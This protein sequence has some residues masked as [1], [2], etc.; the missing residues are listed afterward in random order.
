MALELKAEDRK[1]LGKKVNSLRR[2]GFI[3][4]VLYG[5]G[6]KSVAL[7]VNAK[8]FDNVFRQAGE[9]SLVHLASGG[10]KHNVLIHDTERDVLSGQVTHIDFFEVKMDE[11][12]KAK[13]PLVFMGEAPAVKA[14]GGVLVRA[15]QEVEIEAL[16]QDLPKEIVVDV[17]SLAT[18]EDKVH[19]KDL[20]VDGSIK[21]LTQGDETVAL[22]TPPRSEKEM[23]ELEAK[24]VEADLSEVKVVGEEE[25]AEAAAVETEPPAAA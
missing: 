13:V 1:V 9:T 22:V 15:L 18:F 6:K 8:E 3:P 20:K 21:I 17:S 14:E 25:K 4:A 12:L 7:T 23:E 10:K 19:V 24:P 2:S 11:K 16:P 5:H